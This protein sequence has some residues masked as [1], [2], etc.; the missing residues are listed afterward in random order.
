[1]QYNANY[2]YKFKKKIGFYLVKDMN[3]Q[4]LLENLL[5]HLCGR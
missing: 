4:N 2:P 5:D 3:N 1:M